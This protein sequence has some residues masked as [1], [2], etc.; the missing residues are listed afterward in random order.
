V[1][2]TRRTF[3][4]RTLAAL[5]SGALPARPQSIL[6]LPPPPPG[7]RI[8]YGDDPNQ[9]GE[10]RLPPGPGPHP[11][12]VFIHGGYWFAAYDLNHASHLCAAVAKAGYAVWSLEYRRIGQPGAGY[13]GTFDDI[14][15][16]AKRL[17]RIPNL[18]LSR[19]AV[20][21]HSAGGQLA[22]WLAAQSTI[23]LRSVA[24]LA[25]VT[26]LRLGFD[27]NLGGGAVRQLMGCPPTQCS[28]E[29]AKA[30]PMDLLPIKV[31]QRVLHGTADD[32][33]PFELSQ[34]FVSA[35]KNAKLVPLA[36]ANHFDL[37]DPRSKAWPTVL[38][39]LTEP[40]QSA[41]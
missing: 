38:R 16:G 23:E 36:D 21:G 24:A 5:A 22:L 34:R 4:R 10:L 20:A 1:P 28:A 27:L 40:L 7:T 31:P 2:D 11:V 19:I 29:Y 39:N 13:P 17:S 35:S 8:A 32:I 25:A 6:E 41:K 30:S 9:F 26:D 18:D 3:A 37:I 12:L 14:R 33:V 15:A